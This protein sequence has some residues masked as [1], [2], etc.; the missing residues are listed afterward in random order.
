MERKTSKIVM[1]HI[2][3][4]DDYKQWI[5]EIRGRYRQSQIKAAVKVN[6]EMLQF[7][8]L[9]GR[10]IVEREMENTYGSGFFKRLSADL[11]RELPDAK[12][13]SPINIRYFKAFYELYSPL[14]QNLPQVADDLF[15]IP[16]GHHVQ[17]INKC[18][19][20]SRMFDWDKLRRIL[21]N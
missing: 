19:S 8:W 17:I 9:L 11:P 5:S 13:F 7:Y 3:T 15:S 1:K 4:T 10:D 18:K 16:W 14:L 21:E 2:A 6:S 20:D 12:G